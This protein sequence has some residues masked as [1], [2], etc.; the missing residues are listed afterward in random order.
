M[1]Q[2]D[3]FI[4]FWG[5]RGSIACAGPETLEYGGNTPCVEMRIGDRLIILDAGTGLF[6]LGKS[7]DGE[8]PLEADLLFSHMHMDHVVGLPFF[9]PFFNEA[10]RFRLRS[11]NLAPSHSLHGV[12]CTL[13]KAPMF[14]VPP[15]IF[16]ADITYEDFQA[17]S[18]LDLGDGIR[19]RTAPLNHPNGATGYRIE[20]DGHAI[21]YVT[22]TEHVPGSPDRKILDLI[23]GADIVIYDAHFS[24]AVFE[25]YQGW[26]H[27]T[28]EEGVRLC[29]AAGARTL[30]LFHHDP[31]NSD[32]AMDEIARSAEAA[33][34]GTV[35][36]REGMVL[37]P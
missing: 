15:A 17:G 10:N 5:V 31:N 21:C 34:P 32:S 37:R 20:A 7:L 24:D 12:I 26:G 2:R 8:M 29:D 36:A 28:W 19:V 25:K 1:A 9:T 14:P 3:I 35:A 22:D 13:M 27:S 33:R 11:G 16:Q 23:G 6:P 30:V 18:V 4:R